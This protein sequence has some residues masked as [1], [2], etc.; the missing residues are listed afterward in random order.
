[1]LLALE[2]ARE[3]NL[4]SIAFLGGDG[5]KAKS[6]AACALIVPHRDTA[7]VQEGHQFLM[8]CLMDGIEAWFRNRA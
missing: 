5:G 4:P 7:R 1:V 6:S 8:H 3:M 2:A